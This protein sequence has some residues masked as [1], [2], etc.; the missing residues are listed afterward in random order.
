MK[1]LK[2]NKLTLLLIGLLVFTACVEDDEYNLPN[3][4]VNEVEFGPDDQMIDIDAVLGFFNQSGEAYTFEDNPNFDVYTSGYV[5]SS[6]EGG[7][8]FEELVLQDKAEN[9]TAGVVVQIDVNPLYTI[10]EFGRKVYIKLDG[11]TIAED[12]GVLQLGRAAG[13]GI[14]KIAAAQRAEHIILDPEVATI[15][16]LDVEISDFSNDL[17]NLFIRL[18]D[19]QFNRNDVL[20]DNPLTFAAEDSDEFDGERTIESCAN[21]TTVIMSTS[22]FSDFK[23]LTLPANRGSISAV[24]TRDFFDDFY[25]IVVNSPEDI[26]F[27]NENRCD[28]DFLE[29]TGPSGGGAVIFEEDFEGFGTYDSEGWDNINI[30]GTSTDWFISSFSGNFYSRISAF[31]SGNTEANVWLVTPAIDM[32]STTGEEISFDV[33]SNFDNGT[34]LSV[35]VSTD[36]AGDPTTA[37]WSL[38]DATIP[39]GPSSTFGD[40]E[41]VGPVNISCVEG[42]AVFGFFY[43]GSDPSA[44][45]RYHLD[46]IVVTGN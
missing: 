43:E 37:T 10:Y 28:P 42:T 12:N 33:Q 39:V 17:E 30:N 22:T 15:V 21:G 19:M 27:D 18:N 38:L 16:P 7:N 35:W 24:L 40:F 5:I 13:N 8:F 25:T 2:I 14:D 41:S 3:L 31:S 9:P 23:G 29:C 44:T 32:D 1:T 20:G 4:T 26:V 45:T 36:Y 34:N 46:N 6:D 11:L